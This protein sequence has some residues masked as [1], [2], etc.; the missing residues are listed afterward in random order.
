MKV[1]V[2]TAN[3]VKIKKWRLYSDWID[4]AIFYHDYKS[5]LI[6]MRISR[7]N[8]KQFRTVSITRFHTYCSPESIG[9]LTQMEKNNEH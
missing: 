3:D 5:Y 8:A 6:Q 1:N 2:L 7:T 4:I 9:D